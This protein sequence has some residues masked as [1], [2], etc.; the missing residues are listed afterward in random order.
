MVT[1]GNSGIGKETAV[2]LAQ[3]GA[4][5]VLTS[6]D[7]AKGERA[8]AHVRRRAGSD[9][10]HLV[11]LD[12]A[13]LASVRACA[14]QFLADHDRLDV[15]VN[16]AGLVV[17]RRTTTVDGFEETIGVN[18]FGPF[19]LTTLLL[20]RLRTSAPSRV[21][22]VS[23]VAH[24]GSSA[25]ALVTDLQS[26]GGPYEQMSVYAKSK[27]ANILFTRELARRLHGTGVTANCLHPGIIRSGFARAGDAKGWLRVAAALGAPFMGSPKR[28]ARTS[29]Y[30]ASDPEV[31]ET[32]G[33][34]FVR[35]RPR[36]TSPLGADPEAGRW[37]WA[38][39]ERLVAAAAPG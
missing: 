30:L 31:A 4:T 37:L 34:Y 39:S 24:Q 1:G 19:L 22:V 18:H 25:G 2:G 10:V 27:L 7:R 16:N 23:S 14:E 35:R 17:G 9:D 11:P 12:L 38:E 21:V 26:E 15:L 20:D 13:S 8:V 29:I 3:L 6:R 5:V 36:P 32:T 28:G 33:E